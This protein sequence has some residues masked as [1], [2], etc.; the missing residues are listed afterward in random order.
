VYIWLP[1]SPLV[2]HWHASKVD[3]NLEPGG[4]RN[5]EVLAGRVAP[6]AG[7]VGQRVV[8]RAEIGRRDSHR[9][10]G[11]AELRVGLVVAHDPEALPARRAVV[12]QRRRV[13]LVPRRV[14]VPVATG[15]S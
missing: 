14:K 3:A 15:S 6:A 12:E 7:V 4:L 13:R 9:R 8:G 10:A 11:D 2:E 5:I 1:A